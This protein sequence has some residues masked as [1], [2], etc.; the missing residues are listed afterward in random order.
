MK[1]IPKILLVVI[2]G[3]FLV[4]GLWAIDIGASAMM[5]SIGA[6][7]DTVAQGLF[8]IRS[9]NTQYHLGMVLIILAFLILAAMY[10]H[11]V[12]RGKE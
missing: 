8:G 10:L 3:I 2:L 12:L 4:S 7:M 9:P 11:E 1:L 5:M 6:G